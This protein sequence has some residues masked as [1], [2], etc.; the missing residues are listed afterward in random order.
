MSQTHNMNHASMRQALNEVLGVIQTRFPRN[1]A[2]S[3]NGSTTEADLMGATD[4]GA[5][6]RMI[7]DK[8]DPPKVK[9]N[10]KAKPKPEPVVEVA[11]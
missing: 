11:A 1:I 4:P 2:A 5:F 7:A 3:L 6:L 9:K 8:I 10:G